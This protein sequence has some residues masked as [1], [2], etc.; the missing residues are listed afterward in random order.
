M[1]KHTTNLY[2]YPYCSARQYTPYM[3]NAAGLC[4]HMSYTDIG[5]HIL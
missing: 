2:K 1:H 4:K 5:R 3:A